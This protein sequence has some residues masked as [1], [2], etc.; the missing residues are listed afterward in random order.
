IMA[1]A[2]GLAYVALAL[3][4]L[5]VGAAHAC[6]T[7][8]YLYTMENWARDPYVI[9]YF[10]RGGQA[11]A[12]AEV[13]AYLDRVAA[14]SE[15]HANISFRR[16]D[17]N[18]AA[19]LAFR[20]N[21]TIW[22]RNKDRKLPFHAVISPKGH[23][24]VAGRLDLAEARALVSSPGRTRLAGEL[25]RGTHGLLLLVTGSDEAESRAA[26]TAVA[27]MV[28]RSKSER[29]EVGLVEVARTDPAERWLVRQAMLL[30]ADLPDLDNAMVFPV[31]GRGHVLEPYLGKGITVP[32]LSD[33]VEF[34]NGPC[35][36]EVKTASIGMD[37]LT[38]FDWATR[39]TPGGEAQASRPGFA[40][41]DIKEAEPSEPVCVMPTAP[42]Q[43]QR[44]ARAAEQPAP[45]TRTAPATRSAPAAPVARH[46][47]G[48]AP[49]ATAQGAGDVADPLADQGASDAGGSGTSAPP[50]EAGGGA[51]DAPPPPLTPG[52]GQ[53]VATGP[54]VFGAGPAS[55]D[56]ALA[57][58]PDLIAASKPVVQDL[59]TAENAAPLGA[60]LSVG[61]G[62]LIAAGT[63]VVLLG[64]MFVVLRRP[65]H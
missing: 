20:E 7:P 39:Q 52:G 13:N 30:E 1:R 11:A 49:P 17:V 3:L 42:Q 48:A 18:D 40:L 47:A 15:G 24:L 41:V 43:P 28:S 12:D 58:G 31:F 6:D 59:A 26:R 45:A 2:P 21:Q 54:V 62:L 44:T 8:V 46:E 37:L 14:G 4:A 36:C 61:L 33:V 29:Q 9:R 51:G 16:V 50:H 57:S 10:H 27:E 19:A 23:E 38:D 65:A 55:E 22:Q 56:R 35:A 63:L 34:M 53:T 64:G 25:A 60:S 5:A 32:R